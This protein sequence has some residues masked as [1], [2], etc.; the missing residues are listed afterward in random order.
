MKRFE[1]TLFVDGENEATMQAKKLAL[2]TKISGIF[3]IVNTSG[4]RHLNF[5]KEGKQ[6]RENYLLEAP[7]CFTK[8]AIYTIMNSFCAQPLKFI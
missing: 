1:Y 5:S 2:E 8:V 3:T 4:I 6:M 7:T